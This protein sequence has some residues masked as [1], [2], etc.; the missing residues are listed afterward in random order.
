MFAV[1]ALATTSSIDTTLQIAPG[2]F[3]P[4]LSAGHPDDGQRNETAS[5]LAWLAAGGRGID[6][7][8]SYHNQQ[9]VGAAVR[10]S[11]LARS[12]IFI[13]TKI[14]CGEGTAEGA[15]KSIHDDLSQLGLPSVD[16]MLIHFPC[17]RTD[18]TKAVWGA[19]Q[20][21]HAA[22]LTRAIGVSNF[23]KADL[24][25]ALSLGGVPPAVN[26]CAM[27]IGS[28]DDGTIAYGKAHNVTYEAYSPL[29]HVDLK[30][31]RITSIAAAHQVTTAQI[32]L[33]WIWQQDVLI[34][35]S[36]GENADYIKEDL[37]LGSF[38][39]AEDEMAA[40]SNI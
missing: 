16:L 5:A 38:T 28:H 21:A 29:R 34:A 19:L 15:T 13:T 20:K 31:P 27:A 17:R 32:A 14:P 23:E 25:A 33:K 12:E 39:L 6:T 35:T 24:D 7:A 10:T 3:M 26:Q 11:G 1:I 22:G 36:P 30:D 4:R 40:L 18:Q 9:Q 8:F 37:T 2:V